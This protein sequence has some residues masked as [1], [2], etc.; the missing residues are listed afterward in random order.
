MKLGIIG[1]GLIVQEFLPKLVQMDGMKIEGILGV[2]QD[3][4]HVK[5]LCKE[6]Q[7]PLATASFE[8]LC[9]S[10]ID[11]VYVAVPN[12]LHYEFCQKALNHG[13]NVIVEKPMTSNLK[14]AL[15][16]KELA[17]SKKLFIFEAI[18]TLY[19]DTYKKIQEWLPK[20][21]DIKLVQSQYSQYSRRFDAFKN[22]E[23]LPVFDPKKAGGALMDLS[24]YN[25]H[26]VM[27]LF[28]K[29]EEAKYYSNIEKNIDTSGLLV[30]KYPS[31][32][33]CCVGAKDSHGMYGGMIQG[34][35]GY[36]KSTLPPNVVG[37]VILH[38]NDG[39]EERFDDNSWKE[40][41]IPEFKQ[42]IQAIN[43]NDLNYCYKQ[44]EKSIAVCDVQTKARID[45]GIIFPND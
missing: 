45:A 6:H 35:K 26:Y 15:S 43:D 25:L 32:I 20:I 31:F 2:P 40:R 24:L 16:L 3:L 27:G 29:P 34:T 36:I 41:L 8:E 10:G 7:I 17:Q 30:L 22:G 11:T 42:F 5:N 21:G 4:D 23:V 28:G 13:L 33:A 39:T 14:E 12:F 38:L 19:L 44:L 9:S 1:S 37:E 18:T